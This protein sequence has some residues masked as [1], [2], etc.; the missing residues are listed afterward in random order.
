MLGLSFLGGVHYYIAR[1]LV[2]DPGIAAPWRELLIGA[3]LVL[4]ATLLVQPVAER[5]LRPALARFVAWPAALWMGFAFLILIQLFA[6]DAFLWLAGSVALAAP[7][8]EG[9]GGASGL[10]AALVAGVAFLAGGAALRAGLRPPRLVRVEIPLARWPRELDGFRIV[11]I[12]DVHIGPLL[13]RRFAAD[14]TRRVNA[15]EPDLVAVTGDLVD[16]GV[17]QL[18]DEVAP[19]AGLCGRHGVFF[20]TGNHDHYSGARAWAARAAE[21]GM[22][23][24]RN[25][26]VE[27]RDGGVVFDLVGVD[28]HRGDVLARDGREDLGRA[29]DGRDP[30]RPAVLLAH[31]P[32]TFK[33][34][35]RLGIDLQLSGH[36]HGG[37]IW[38]FRWFVRLAVPFVAGRYERSGAELYVSRGTGFWGPPMRLFAPAEITELTLRAAAS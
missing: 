10:R 4:G 7:A 13:D 19:F 38:P 2:I 31:D 34:A 24:L 12:S 14:L 25:E 1:R 30:E 6:T 5:T 27:I 36:T 28:D 17:E 33:R 21:L 18:R 9:S 20:V 15:L 29:L 22:C 3:L 11:Q 37:Q 26:R 8:A 16:G 23:V 32:S 35:S